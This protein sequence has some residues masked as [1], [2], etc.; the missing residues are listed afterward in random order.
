SSYAP[1][2]WSCSTLRS[3]GLS[4]SNALHP[5]SGLNGVD[6]YQQGHPAPSGSVA[7]LHAGCHPV[8]IPR[9]KKLPVPEG[10]SVCVAPA[11][12][13]LSRGIVLD[14]VWI[15]TLLTGMLA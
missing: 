7:T 2:H 8:T 13:P 10:L 6:P 3:R 5:L 15:R 11:A 4:G 1:F 12:Y 9:A 14:A